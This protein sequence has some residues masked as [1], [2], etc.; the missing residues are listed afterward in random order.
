MD[1]IADLHTHTVAS[2]HAYSTLLE[3]AAYAAT[4]H[5]LVLGISDHAPGMP[6]TTDKNYFFNV[7]VWP[8]E[9][10]GVH[11][12]RGAEVNVLNNDGAIDLPEE[13][14]K[15]LDYVIVSL[16]QGIFKPGQEAHINT[17]ALIAAMS[18]TKVCA[19]GHP[20]DGRFPIDYSRLAQAAKRLNKALE[21]NESSLSPTTIRKNSEENAIAMLEACKRESAWVMVNSDSHIALSIGFFSRAKYLLEKCRFPASLI[22]NASASKL[23]DFFKQSISLDLHYAEIE[24]P[25][26]LSPDA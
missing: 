4:A 13:A 1:F 16:H 22:V 24:N 11:I 26:R 14:L 9:L 8:R 3:N 15:G 19:I 7:K 5:L 10:F 6:E 2:R 20:D 23:N 12:L 21:L 18:H 17:N 25:E